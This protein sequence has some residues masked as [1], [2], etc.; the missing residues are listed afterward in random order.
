MNFAYTPPADFV[1]PTL[2]LQQLTV[3]VLAVFVG[4]QVIRDSGSAYAAYECDQC[5]QRH[6]RGGLLQV[7]GQAGM[8]AVLLGIVAAF[9]AINVLVAS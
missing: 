9:F 3:F 2:F 5:H 6:Y 4:W 7:N 8:L 1:A